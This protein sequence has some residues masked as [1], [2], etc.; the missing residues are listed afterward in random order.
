MGKDQ[1]IQLLKA[2]KEQLK[3]KFHFTEIGLFGSIVRGEGKEN[4]DIDVL[5]D[6]NEDADI[7]DLVGLSLFL[8]EKFKQKVD[9]VPRRALRNEI[10]AGV[11][12]D[13]ISV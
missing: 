11:L 4:S 5:V 6:F 13:L 9:V 3:K 12:K 10:E 2:D 8:E 1:I 7:F